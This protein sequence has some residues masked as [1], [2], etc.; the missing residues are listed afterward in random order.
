[1]NSL[2]SSGG[3]SLSLGRSA[4]GNIYPRFTTEEEIYSQ[5]LIRAQLFTYL[6]TLCCAFYRKQIFK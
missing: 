3:F 5:S 6:G 4:D 1:M 2:P